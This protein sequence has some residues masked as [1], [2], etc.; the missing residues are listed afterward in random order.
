MFKVMFFFM[1]A[2]SLINTI[3]SLTVLQL[4]IIT[5]ISIAIASALFVCSYRLQG[6]AHMEICIASFIFLFIAFI[7]IIN[8]LAKIV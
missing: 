7:M 4:L 5:I 2:S 6:L 3:L 1:T 8:M